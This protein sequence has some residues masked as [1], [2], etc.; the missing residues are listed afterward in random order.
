MAARKFDDDRRFVWEIS[1][2]QADP[3]TAMVGH[4]WVKVRYTGPA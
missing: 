1:R 2:V 3:N 4:R